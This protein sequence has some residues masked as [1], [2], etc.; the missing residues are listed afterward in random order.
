VNVFLLGNYDG[1]V[2]LF[3]FVLLFIMHMFIV[4]ILSA[5]KWLPLFAADV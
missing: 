1:H 2:V 3:C 4:L 5:Y